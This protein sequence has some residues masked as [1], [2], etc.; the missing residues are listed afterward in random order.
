MHLLLLLLLEMTV[1]ML[2]LNSLSVRRFIVRSLLN[3]ATRH[4]HDLL[5]LLRHHHVV[6]LLLGSGKLLHCAE[7]EMGDLLFLLWLTGL[8]RHLLLV[9]LLMLLSG[10]HFWHHHL[11][12]NDLLLALSLWKLLLLMLLA[13]GLES[14]STRHEAL[15]GYLGDALLLLLLVHLLL[16]LHLV[17]L[18]HLLSD[19]LQ[20]V[21]LLGHAV[22]GVLLLGVLLLSHAWLA[23]Y[24]VL[25]AC[26]HLSLH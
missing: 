21:V 15:E 9:S 1:V 13:I 8:L 23:G 5:Q 20:I 19:L 4:N 24:E 26:W 11:A 16:L 22:D 18:I 12:T 14:L 25:L 10:V 3:R 7:A 17:L 6:L 2:R